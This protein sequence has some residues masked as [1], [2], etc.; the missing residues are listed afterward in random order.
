MKFNFEKIKENTKKIVMGAGVLASSYGNLEAEDAKPKNTEQNKMEVVK[1]KNGD[2]NKESTNRNNELQKKKVLDQAKINQL[3]KDLGIFND[4]DN[5]S[6][7]DTYRNKY[8]AYMEH[9]SYKDRLSKEIYGDKILDEE[10]KENLNQEYQDRLDQL[11]NVSIHLDNN[12]HTSEF[13]SKNNQINSSE[14][15][16]F[17]ELSHAVENNRHNS[18]SF[19]VKVIEFKL[20][21][22]LMTEKNRLIEEKKVP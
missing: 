2:D 19:E 6:K 18:R 21:G 7:T 15:V 5:S 4:D 20:E 8:Q 16:I 11:K 14:N 17:H 13:T 1:N 12:S 9:P 3:E 10:M 22:K